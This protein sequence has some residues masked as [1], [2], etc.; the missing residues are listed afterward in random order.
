MG[1][2]VR[3]Q[4]KGETLPTGAVGVELE[5]EAKKMRHSCVSITMRIPFVD[6]LP[7]LTL[8]EESL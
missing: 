1:L 2:R 7:T 4:E 8:A 5:P 3:G 6:K